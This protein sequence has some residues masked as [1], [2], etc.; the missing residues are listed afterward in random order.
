MTVV[1][2]GVSGAIGSALAERFLAEQPGE[3]LIGLARTV[4]AVNARVREHPAVHLIEWQAELPL[5]M[6]RYPEIRKMLESANGGISVIYAAGLLHDD[7]VA[8]EKRVE[9]MTQASMIQAFQVNCLGF[10]VLVQALAPWLRGKRLARVAA[11]SAKVG[12][13]EDN[14]LGGWYAYRCSKAALNM[15][16]KNLSVELPRRYA[17]IACVALH[18][19]T[20]RS[21]LSAPFSQSLAKLTV[22]EPDATAA[23]LYEVLSGL[24][25]EDNGR[26]ISWNG[27]DLPW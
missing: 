9:D 19:G 26:F 10:G 18:P 8:P 17:P 27:Q 3:P 25:E 4:D 12:S 5:D 22:H 2:A 7:V 11:V 23:N 1:I 13:I 14:R 15:M 24:S 21:N 6:A 20:T 16:V